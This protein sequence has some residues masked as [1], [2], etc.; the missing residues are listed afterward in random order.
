MTDTNFFDNPEKVDILLK[1]AFGFPSTSENKQ[2]Y[3]ETAVNYNNYLN[4]EDLFLDI[5]PQIPDFDSSGIVRT[6]SELGLQNSTF[7]SYNDNVSNK[8]LCS[9]VDD[10]TS[11][12]RRFQN[13]ILEQCP[14]LGSDAGASWFKLDSSNNNILTDAFQFNYKQYSTNGI[15]YQPYLYSLYTQNSI[16]SSSPNLPFGQKG[17]NWFFDLKSGIL[18]FSDFINFS[19]GVQTNPN[20]QI[21]T[22]NNFPVLSFYKYIGRKGINSFIPS[23]SNNLN[24]LQIAET[25]LVQDLSDEIIE[26]TNY[27]IINDLSLAVVSMKNN[28]KYK[29]LLNFNYLSSNYYDTLLKVTMCYKINNGQEVIIG[30]YLLGNEN[31]SFKYDFFSN[32]FYKNI[33]SNIGDNINFYIKAKI[34]SNNSINYTTIDDIYKPK[35]ILSSLGNIL[36]IEEVNN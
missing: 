33:I 26:T 32:N 16:N 23:L 9:I 27:Q 14:Q 28:S 22:T 35:I 30:E 20:F 25:S 13:V 6:A 7:I 11:N 31:T 18:F 4:G 21:N 19:N 12:V 29:I 5:I 17:G 1:Q 15:T 36:N 34:H 8:S 24:I 2:W 3:E 10:S